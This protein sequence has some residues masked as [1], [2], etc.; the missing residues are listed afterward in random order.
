MIS[1]VKE[2]DCDIGIAFD[3]DGDRCLII[4]NLGKVLWPDKQMMVYAKDILSTNKNE[5]IVYDVKSSKDLA[6]IVKEYEGIPVIC[7]TGHSYIKM[8]MKET[9]AIL[10][11]EMSGHIF[12]KDRWYGFDDGIYAGLRMLE[13]VSCNNKTS[14][15]IFMELPKSYSTP[16][17]NIPVDKDGFQHEFMEKFSCS[18]IIKDAEITK[19]DG[20][21]ADFESGWGLIRASNTTP[22][23]VMRF[24]AKSEEMLKSIQ[25]IFIKEI[26]KIDSSLEIPNETK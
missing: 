1:C 6:N 16:E 10:G 19:I 7:R 22:C 25:D 3:G 21:R 23:L 4:D 24:E 14:S 9:S 13:I 12:F 26:F 15:E 2:N 17:I 8:K 11:G 20:V 5:K 18:A